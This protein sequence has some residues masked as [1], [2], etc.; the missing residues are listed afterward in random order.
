[1]NAS[2]KADNEN[3]MNSMVNAI[4]NANWKKI[5]KYAASAGAG[6]AAL[7]FAGYEFGRDIAD[8][9]VES[10]MGIERAVVGDLIAKV[11]PYAGGVIG[12]LAAY[13]SDKIQKK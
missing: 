2:H 7:G 10:K 6:A 8:L 3:Y 4:Y 11:S 13:V 9:F 5:A 1:M 12:M